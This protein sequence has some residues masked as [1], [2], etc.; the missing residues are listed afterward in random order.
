LP[1]ALGETGVRKAA[2]ARE[3]QNS[4]TSRVV[5]ATSSRSATL[6]GTLDV[7]RWILIIFAILGAGR[8]IGTGA[9]Y[10]A[11]AFTIGGL[12]LFFVRKPWYAYYK[13][14]FQLSTTVYASAVFFLAAGSMG[15]VTNLPIVMA[16][17]AEEVKAERLAQDR[18]Y[19]QLINEKVFQPLQ[20]RGYYWGLFKTQWTEVNSIRLLAA[21]QAIDLNECAHVFAADLANSRHFTVIVSCAGE[22]KKIA[23]D[24]DSLRAGR[25]GYVIPKPQPKD[26]EVSEYTDPAATVVRGEHA[27][28]DHAITEEEFNSMGAEVNRQINCGGACPDNNDNSWSPP[29]N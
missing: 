29:D 23:Y 1:E 10:S 8:S 28:P 25:K 27:V 9:L 18:H 5:I 19:H 21:M 12:G 16:R 6:T 2:V 26:S 20:P 13:R 24:L 7:G 11:C 3:A 4:R 22:Y 17:Y 15:Y 14:D